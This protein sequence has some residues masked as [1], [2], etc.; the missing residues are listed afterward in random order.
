MLRAE[1]ELGNLVEPLRWLQVLGIWPVGDFRFDP[2]DMDATYVL[3]G[4]L[5]VAGMAGL[6]FAWLRR[7]WGPLL[8]LAGAGVGVVVATQ[9]GSPWVDGK[10]MTT[11]SPA[12]VLFG[13]LGAA[14]ILEAARGLEGRAVGALAIAAIAAG[15]LWSNALAYREVNLAPRDRLAELEDIADRIA[16]EGPTLMTDYEPYGVRHFLRDAEPEG[17]SEFRRRQIPLNDGGILEKL[18]VA[19]IDEFQLPAVLVYRSLVLRRSA[20]ASRPPSVYRLVS[21]GRYYE[22]WQRNEIAA[23]PPGRAILEHLPLGTKV[24]PTAAPRCRDVLRLARKAGPR[25]RLATVER[26]P[27][28][29]VDLATVPYP[30][31]WTPIPLNR[32]SLSPVTDGEVSAQ[33]DLPRAGRYGFWLGGAFRRRLE[34]VV[35]GEQVSAERQQLSHAGHYVPMGEAELSKGVHDVVLRY[36]DGGLRPGTRGEAFPIGPLVISLSTADSPV[37]YLPPSEAT[38]LCGKRLDWIEALRS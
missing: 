16:G 21:R 38:S 5:V 28:T 17:A 32:S 14:A 18:E 10:A 12:F 6:V 11:A 9:L 1:S 23:Q 27:A 2:A 34:L 33:I 7:A 4:V 31:G 15:L 36:G 8:Y 20:V 22:L 25:G 24:E 29:A 30:A 19:D 37:R 3:L 26:A 35:D 13:L